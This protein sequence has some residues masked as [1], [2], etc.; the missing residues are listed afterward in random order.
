MT[1]IVIISLCLKTNTAMEV[2]IWIMKSSETSPNEK[3][4]LLRFYFYSLKIENLEIS[5]KIIMR[6][7]K[8]LMF[9]IQASFFTQL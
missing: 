5:Y 8:L 3:M 2:P 6:D 1:L 4:F 7:T 9:K